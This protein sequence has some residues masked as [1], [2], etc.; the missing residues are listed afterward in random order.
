MMKYDI[1]KDN[2]LCCD[3][4]CQRCANLIYNK[5][6]EQKAEIIS[7][8]EAIE[9]C[10]EVANRK[11]DDCGKEHLQLAK[12]LEELKESRETINRQEAEI[13]RLKNAYKQCAWERDIFAEDYKEEIRKDI[14]ILQVDIN[15]V[16][17]KARKEFWDRLKKEAITKYDWN[18][19]IEMEC[20]DNL[21]E[22]MEQEKQ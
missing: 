15:K 9:H 22:E 8:D 6:M 2:V 19:Y 16:K 4:N 10:Y 14:S 13:E 7:L 20:G 11:C 3:D 1:C 17:S 5:Y 18:D 12:W 21:L